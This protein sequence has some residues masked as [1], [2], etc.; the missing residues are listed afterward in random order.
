MTLY[1]CGDYAA[2]AEQMFSYDKGITKANGV[3]NDALKLVITGIVY[4]LMRVTK[5][6]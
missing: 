2:L 4:H 5:V 6:N 1:V 3:Y